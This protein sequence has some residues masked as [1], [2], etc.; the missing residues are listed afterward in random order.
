MKTQLVFWHTGNQ[1][2]KKTLHDDGL[3]WNLE[4]F[5]IPFVLR[6]PLSHTESFHLRTASAWTNSASGGDKQEKKK[7]QGNIFYVCNYFTCRFQDLY[8]LLHMGN[9]HGYSTGFSALKKCK[10]SL[11]PR[12]KPSSFKCLCPMCIIPVHSQ[13]KTASFKETLDA[14]AGMRGY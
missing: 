7:I 3:I 5:F 9:C 6:I 8:C 11:K 4:S 12:P 10:M 14:K 13:G 1:T 2:Q